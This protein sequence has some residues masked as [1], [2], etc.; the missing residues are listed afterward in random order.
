MMYSIKQVAERTNL[1]AHV[2]R[3]YEKEGLL[4]YVSRTE[5]G[6]RRY[7]E[8]DL[9]WLGLINCLKNTG[10]SIKQIKAFVELSMQGEATLKDRCDMLEEHRQSVLAEIREMQAHLEKV[11]WKIQHFTA[12]YEKSKEKTPPKQEAI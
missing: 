9:E 7:S 8:D 5:S 11:S 3:Y 1:K 4:P 6:I 2:L 12:E 10:M